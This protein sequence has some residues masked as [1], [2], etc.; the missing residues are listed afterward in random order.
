MGFLDRLLGR[1]PS[2][3]TA[4]PPVPSRDSS[5]PPRPG[6][7]DDERAIARYRYLVRTASPEQLEAVHAEAFEKLT[8]EQRHELLRELSQS[9]PAGEQ[10]VSAQPADLARAATRA[11]MRQPGYLHGAMSR[12]SFGRGGAFAGSMLGTVAG[13]VAGSM[14]ASTLMS[15]FDQ[16]PEAAETG[17]AG[18]DAGSG[19]GGSGDSGGDVGAV[20]AS[21]D[22]GS[23]DSGGFDSGGFDSGGGDFGGGFG[24]GDFGGF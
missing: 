19:E 16:S 2:A 23:V 1:A 5:P 9:A 20:E 10:P 17:E 24:G 12:G 4:Y 3:A 18:S 15:G 11:E 22:S 14:I 8:T 21:A 6:R 7:D 13:V